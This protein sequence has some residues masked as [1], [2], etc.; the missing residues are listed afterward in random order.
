[1]PTPVSRTRRT[2]AVALARAGDG[3]DAAGWRVARGV[4][5][6]VVD[7]LRE[8]HF[9]ALDREVLGGH[10]D[11]ETVLSLLEQRRRRFDGMRHDASRDPAA[12]SRDVTAPR[13][14]R[15]TSSRSST[16]RTRCFTWR[17]MTSSIATRIRVAAALQEPRRGEDRA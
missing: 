5:E 17:T 9:V 7:H 4:R 15:E 8:S 11:L 16:S 1:M 14:T 13:A 3:D 10:G 2:T 6:Q 12:S